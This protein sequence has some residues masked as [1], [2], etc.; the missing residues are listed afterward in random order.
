MGIYLLHLKH[1]QTYNQQKTVKN[2]QRLYVKY[3][4]IEYREA[5][6]NISENDPYLAGLVDT[7]GTIVYNYAGNRIEC[8]L[9]FEYNKYTSKLNLDNV[10]P[11]YKPSV[12]FRESHKSITFKYQTVK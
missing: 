3:L 7:D 11:Y 10:I 1:L 4:N 12:A 8:N 9:E 5:N 2:S 6:Y